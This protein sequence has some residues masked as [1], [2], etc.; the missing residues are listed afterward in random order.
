MMKRDKNKQNGEYREMTSRS[1]V[2][3]INK[4][5]IVLFGI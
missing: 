3:F 2:N 5:D 4:D 1:Y